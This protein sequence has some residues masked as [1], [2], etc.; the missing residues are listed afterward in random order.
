[1]SIFNRR[2]VKEAVN[3]PAKDVIDTIELIDDDTE[4]EIAAV[5]AAVC[6]VSGVSPAGLVVRNIIRVPD[7]ATNWNRPVIENN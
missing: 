7:L 1:M 4:D 2:K 3:E 6:C 5:I